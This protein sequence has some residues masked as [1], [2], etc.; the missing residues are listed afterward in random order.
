MSSSSIFRNLAQVDP[1]TIS[2]QLTP[3]QVAYANTLRRMVLTGVEG[4]AF[5]S[6]MNDKG[7]T[8][9]VIV[10]SNTTPMTNEM[11]ADR[12]GLIPIH[13]ETP[14]SWNPDEYIFE[15]NVVNDSTDV[16]DVTTA[17]FSVKKKALS[18]G[19]EDSLVGNKEFFH[20]NPITNDN[21]LIAVLKGKQVNQNPQKIEVLAKATVGTGRDH[22]RFSPVSQ[23]SYSYTIDTDESRQKMFYE[24]WL[25]NN[26]K[27]DPKSLESDSDR[28]SKLQ[29]EFQTMEVQR[30]FLVNEKNEPYSFDFV[31]ET[32][33]VQKP[34]R[35]IERA[36]MNIE[37]KCSLY[38]NMASGTLPPNVRVQ[39]AD[40]RM[41]GFDFIIGK[42][43]HTLGNLIQ[44]W[45]EDN[46]M[47]SGE[48][49][50]VGYKVPHPLRDEMLLRVGVD[51]GQE[52]TARAMVG[53][54]AAACANMFRLWRED[55]IR[56]SSAGAGTR[57]RATLKPTL[58][59][60]KAMVEAKS[61][62]QTQAQT[63]KKTPAAKKTA[64]KV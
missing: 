35:I 6:D 7:A 25:M 27:I 14:G 15:L 49:T 31:V 32:L 48:I 55:W 11:L 17:D 12:I 52:L 38:S 64:A 29:R 59:N 50:Y 10:K 37:S 36:L 62:A 45:M 34:E 39:P 61:Q 20:A 21:V 47:D 5:R 16:R 63:Q 24:R 23:C 42:E 8:T 33:G 9:D 57:T 51:D 28:A 56:V 22:I 1:L 3:T 18:P 30:C 13:V 46:L 40:A 4:V 43:D 26:K 44:T 58:A 19:E 2:F 53:K 41:K 54:A 60:A